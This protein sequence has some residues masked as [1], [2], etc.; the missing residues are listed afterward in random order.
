[1]DNGIKE[2]IKKGN[3]KLKTLFKK[4][5][6]MKYS[7]VKDDIKPI[8]LDDEVHIIKSEEQDNLKL[9]EMLDL[10]KAGREKESSDVDFPE[11]EKHTFVDRKDQEPERINK[12]VFLHQVN[13]ID[14]SDSNNK[15]RINQF[16]KNTHPISIKG[17]P[18]VKNVLEFYDDSPYSSIY[19]VFKVEW[20]Y[21]LEINDDSIYELIPAHR[22]TTFAIT[23][24]GLGKYI[25]CR[26]YR[27]IH[28]NV[29]LKNNENGMNKLLSDDELITEGMKSKRG[30]FDP[31]TLVPKPIQF[32]NKSEYVE[33]V[34]CTSKGPVLIPLE[35]SYEILLHFCVN[36]F[37][38]KVLI[39][40]PLDHLITL[41]SN[42]S[43]IDLSSNE[44]YDIATES[45]Y[46]IALLQMDFKEIKLVFNVN[47]NDILNKKNEAT[48]GNE[49][50]NYNIQ[51]YIETLKNLIFQKESKNQNYFDEHVKEETCEEGRISSHPL[52]Y[53]K[54]IKTF[55]KNE[56]V[57]NLYEIDVRQSLRNDS[58]I[59]CIQN[60]LEEK[61]T[62][63][64]FKLVRI[65]P[66]DQ[67]IDMN[68]LWLHMLSF[69]AAYAFN[70][71][72]KYDWKKNL[73]EGNLSVI[74][75]MLNHYFIHAA[76][77]NVTESLPF[78]KLDIT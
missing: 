31:H 37:S 48:A 3:K 41:C 6:Y 52:S 57:F 9:N 12:G 19:P 8:K 34:S 33:I 10:L 78:H 73:K 74:Q 77:K 16:D 63:E 64:K 36:S 22:G 69:K 28:M 29:Q 67:T 18:F 14:Y 53:L 56:L 4:D 27:R 76:T 47:A 46:F 1:M 59:M 62:S 51:N 24:E 72:S 15:K 50:E 58:I 25:I 70:R 11:F 5:D 38:I 7:Y 13:I 61:S 55:P 26:A 54:S 66:L 75:T 40:D 65:K 2:H 44:N 30:V 21:S 43:S 49:E 60:T 68:R 71:N 17:S 39:E 42:D 45:G 35:I 20:F 23:Y 32:K